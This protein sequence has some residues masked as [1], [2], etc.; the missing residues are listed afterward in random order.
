MGMGNRGIPA[1]EELTFPLMQMAGTS[2]LLSE[3]ATFMVQKF[4]REGL[5]DADIGYME[6]LYAQA[7]EELA[8][9]RGAYRRMRTRRG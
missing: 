1:Q 4:Q 7:G 6:R 3:T 9:A 8:S 5:T 2:G